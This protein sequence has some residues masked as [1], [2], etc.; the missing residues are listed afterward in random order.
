MLLE[1]ALK[2][3]VKAGGS[4]MRRDEIRKTASKR[5]GRQRKKMI[6]GKDDEMVEK[7]RRKEKKID[8]NGKNKRN[9]RDGIEVEEREDYH[10]SMN[11]ESN[12]NHFLFHWVL[13]FVSSLLPLLLP[14]LLFLL[15]VVVVQ[16]IYVRL[17][18][19]SHNTINVMPALVFI[20]V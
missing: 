12:K 15:L 5:V 1:Y 9:S 3:G 8:R 7:I 16:V 13:S 20:T 14:L 10:F 18:I 4:G 6:R 17:T 11:T 19:N 2:N